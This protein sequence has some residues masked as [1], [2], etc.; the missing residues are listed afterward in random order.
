MK[1]LLLLLLIIPTAEA[2]IEPVDYHGIMIKFYNEEFETQEFYDMLDSI[3]L[4]YRE[5]LRLINVRPKT[6]RVMGTYYFGI[7]MI[8]LYSHDRKTMIHE[9]AHYHQD[10]NQELISDMYQHKGNFWKYYEEMSNENS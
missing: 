4:D 2:Y 8:S 7:R 10:L 1:R 3:P 5:G 6:F 9:L